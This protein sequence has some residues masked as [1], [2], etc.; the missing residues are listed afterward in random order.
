MQTD[1]DRWEPYGTREGTLRK[2]LGTKGGTKMLARFI[3][4]VA[5]VCVAAGRLDLVPGTPIGTR[6]V[7]NVVDTAGNV[8]GGSGE[9]GRPAFLAHRMAA[10]P[11]KTP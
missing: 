5:A 9:A 7:A 3:A 6:R 11:P 8:A 4:Q 10:S 2:Q 1:A